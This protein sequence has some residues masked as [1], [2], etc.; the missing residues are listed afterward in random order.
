MELREHSSISGYHFSSWLT[1]LADTF[2]D[3]EGFIDADAP[4]VGLGRL[5]PSASVFIAAAARR[6]CP[7][8]SSKLKAAYRYRPLQTSRQMP[9]MPAG[10]A[11]S[12]RRSGRR[13]QQLYDEDGRKTDDREPDDG[14]NCDADGSCMTAMRALAFF[15]DAATKF[16]VICCTAQ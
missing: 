15:V 1:I 3:I 9:I 12:M 5:T 16:I 7:P 14:V 11:G 6:C 8:R 2:S 10:S 13:V 4:E